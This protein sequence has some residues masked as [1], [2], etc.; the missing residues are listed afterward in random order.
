MGL[1]HQ[2]FTGKWLILM[3]TLPEEEKHVNSKRSD[4]Y[5]LFRLLSIAFVLITIPILYD[6]I[7]SYPAFKTYLLEHNEREAISLAQHLRTMLKFDRIQSSAIQEASGF[8]AR[9]REVM[10]DFNLYKIKVFSPAGQ[11]TFS[12]DP[13]DLAEISRKRDVF[14]TL[15]TGKSVSKLKNKGNYSSEGQYIPLDVVETYVPM[16]KKGQF[17]GAFEIYIDITDDLKSLNQQISRSRAAML[18]IVLVFIVSAILLARTEI[19]VIEEKEKLNQELIR[20]EKLSVVGE[21]AAGVAHEINNILNNIRFCTQTLAFRHRKKT[22]MSNE[23]TKF[24]GII[25]KQIQRGG[26]IAGNIMALS[27]PSEINRTACDIAEAIDQALSINEVYFEQCHIQVIKNYSEVPPVYADIGQ[28]HQLFSNLISNAC[29]ALVPADGGTITILLRESA[30]CVEVRIED[31]GA[32]ISKT[33]GAKIFTPFF[34]TKGAFSKTEVG[35]PGTGLGL[36]IVDQIINNHNGKISFE[37]KRDCGSVFTVTLPVS[38]STRAD[39]PLS[40]KIVAPCL[41]SLPVPDLTILLIDDEEVFLEECARLLEMAGAKGVKTACS[42]EVAR[43]IL[44]Q[45]KFD[46]VFLDLGLPGIS[47]EEFL[48]ELER[49]DPDLKVVIIT[50]KVGLDTESFIQRMNVRA[51]LVKPFTLTQLIEALS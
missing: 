41:G 43:G 15:S 47:G 10:H 50:G 9:I 27:K 46:L 25:D 38:K 48:D 5:R 18:A 14:Q 45:N 8:D 34:T 21:I 28:M 33:D 13:N 51:C 17:A 29:H 12:T 37:S 24:T 31:T 2:P 19:M 44:S 23:I 20:S 49:I 40:P 7:V 3:S 16:M 1:T 26:E 35:T 30:N 42:A 22:D 32:G 11:V 4:K 36:A 6:L 39:E